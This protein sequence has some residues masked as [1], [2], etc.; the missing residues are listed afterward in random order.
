MSELNYEK[1]RK[2]CG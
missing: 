2:Q 1:N